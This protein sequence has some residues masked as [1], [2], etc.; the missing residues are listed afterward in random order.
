MTIKDLKAEISHLNSQ[1]NNQEDIYEK[2]I[3]QLE[4]DLKV[5]GSF[6][7]ILIDSRMI[8]VYYQRLS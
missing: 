7:D 4:S 6:V 8:N 2:R 3:N 1:L 5:Y